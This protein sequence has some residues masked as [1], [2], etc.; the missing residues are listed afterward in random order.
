MKRPALLVIAV[1]VLVW[2]VPSS[3]YGWGS[4]THAYVAHQLVGQGSA[5]MQAIYGSVLADV[6]NTMVSD[7]YRDPLW[8]LTHYDFQKLVDQAQ[9]QSD[10]ALAYGFASHN[11]SWGADRTAHISAMDNPESGYVIR[12]SEELAAILRPSVRLFLLANGVSNPDAVLDA[13]LPTVAHTAIETAVD[14][15][16][17]QSED[18]DLGQR[19]VLAAQTRGWSAPI[20][21]CKAYAADLAATAGTTESVASP[22]IVAAENEFRV[23]MEVYGAAL[24]QDDPIEALAEQGVEL[25]KQLLAGAQ[26]VVVDVPADLMKQ[27]VTAAVDAVKGD[28][29]TEVA[30]TVAQ[31][32]QELESHAIAQPGL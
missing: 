4:A 9:S 30:A 7:P 28:Y 1:S 32:Q 23:Q 14:L 26:G 16:L 13:A 20:L 17:C 10:K 31:V 12:K 5:D 18:P 6:F 3:V 8:T 24:C 11:E 21:L 22:L 2:G 19:L 25:C 29:A 15:L 27:I